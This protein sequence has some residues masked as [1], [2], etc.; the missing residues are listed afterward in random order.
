MSIVIQVFSDYTCPFCLLGQ[1]ALNR[2]AAQTGAQVVWRAYQLRKDGPPRLEPRGA[3]MNQGWQNTV[4]PMAAALGVEMRQPS[5][6][7]LTRYAHEA[8]AW[9]RAQDRFDEF[10]AAILRANFIEDL[11]IGEIETLQQL[12]WRLGLDAADL[13]AALLEQRHADEVDEDL[14]IAETYGVRG[15]PAFVIGGQVMSGVQEEST[16]LRALEATRK[17]EKVAAP[18]PAPL[19]PVNIQRLTDSRHS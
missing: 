16:L 10:H 3:A 17:G 5:R 8:A 6:L 13:A 11:D 2:V 18:M 4:L 19:A 15:V 9:A 14:L 12:A 7:P 1:V